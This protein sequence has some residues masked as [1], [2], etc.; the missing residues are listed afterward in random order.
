MI[1]S[2]RT[3][4]DVLYITHIEPNQCYLTFTFIISLFNSWCSRP[5][6]TH[7]LSSIS[8]HVILVEMDNNMNKIMFTYGAVFFNI[9][10]NMSTKVSAY[11]KRQ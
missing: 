1:V 5:L 6:Y 8:T 7:V 9:L 10:I 2:H 11:N 4:C 3:Q